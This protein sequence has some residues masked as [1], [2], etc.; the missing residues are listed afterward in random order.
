MVKLFVDKIEYMKSFYKR[1]EIENVL[2]IGI[3]IILVF[4]ALGI[5]QPLSTGIMNTSS[6]KISDV[7]TTD[8]RGTQH[9]YT[10]GCGIQITS[11][12][13]NQIV[14]NSITITGFVN[15]CD[16][17]VHEGS[18]G[19]V[20]LLDGTGA[21]ISELTPLAVQ[22]E[23]LPIQF[24][25]TLTRTSVPRGAAGLIVFYSIPDENGKYVSEKFPVRFK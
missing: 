3:G 18:A 21:F 16:W 15:G 19:Y 23:F 7:D 1:G 5:F 20:Q 11:P 24:Q 25:T 12:R 6:Q 10:D 8:G 9:Q 14:S 17:T 4:V 13:Y 22:S 2:I